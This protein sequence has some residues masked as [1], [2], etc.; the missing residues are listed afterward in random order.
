[1]T[2]VKPTFATG[3]ICVSNDV[4]RA[5]IGPQV[6]PLWSI[7]ELVDPRQVN[8]QQPARV[9]GRCVKVIEIHLLI[10]MV[11]PD[12]H[13]VMLVTHYI[14]QLELLEER[15]DRVKALAHLWSCFDG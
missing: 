11:G 12:A 5:A 8:Q 10:A 14:D 7:G 2:E 9:V 3:S 1:M 15:G 6:I 13:K 4:D